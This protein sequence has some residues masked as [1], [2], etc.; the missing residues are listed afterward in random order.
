MNTFDQYLNEINCITNKHLIN[1]P[2]ASNIKSWVYV[3]FMSDFIS[4]IND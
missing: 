2:S 4:S 3:G 1:V